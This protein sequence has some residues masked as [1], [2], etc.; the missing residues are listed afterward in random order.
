MGMGVKFTAAEIEQLGTV[1]KWV[2]ELSGV[3]LPEPAQPQS[4]DQSS[5]PKSPDNENY[6]VLSELVMELMKQGILSNVKCQA[7]LQK[8]KHTETLA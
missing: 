8:L 2:A 4:S 3:A 1:E 5:G 7:M 6:L